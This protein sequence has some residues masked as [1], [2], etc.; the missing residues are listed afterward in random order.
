MNKNILVTGGSGYIGTHVLVSLLKDNF[1]PVVIDN[2]SNSSFKSIKKVQEI[3][4]KNIEFHNCDINDTGKVQDIF[5]RKNFSGVIHLAGLK[6]V[7][8]SCNNPINY[9]ENNFLG[10]LNLLKIMQKNNVNN[11]IFSSSATVYGNPIRVPI[12]ENFE[13]NPTNPYGRSKLMVEQLCFDLADRGDIDFKIKIMLLRYFNPIGAHPSGKIG[14]DPKDIPNN[15]MPYMSQ[16]ASRKLRE[17]TIFGD[18][19][20][21]ID[22]T[23]VRD[24]IHVCDIAEGHVAALK[25]ILDRPDNKSFCTPVN[26]GT[27]RGYSVL[28]LLRSFKNVN[29]LNIPYKFGDRR[30]GDIAECFADSSL[31]NKLLKWKSKKNLDDM[32]KDSW[33]WQKNNPNGY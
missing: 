20:N 6:S 3:T 8:D 17:L 33:N 29:K 18:D 12:K 24:Y 25:Y 11:F 15:I 30:D 23:G 32:V 10:S 14:E 19:Y 22:G 1:V 21:T 4:K 26:L 31:A 7:S 9:Y 16:V 28:Q 5:N 27:G 13:L 2:L